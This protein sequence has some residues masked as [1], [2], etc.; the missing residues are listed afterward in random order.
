MQKATRKPAFRCSRH[1]REIATGDRGELDGV[2]EPLTTD[3]G[4]VAVELKPERDRQGM[5]RE[6]GV[7]LGEVRVRLET[8]GETRRSCSG[9]STAATATPMIAAATATATSTRPS[10][11]R[12]RARRTPRTT[13]IRIA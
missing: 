10:R 9:D 5:F 12:R 6:D 13:A 7:V 1:L 2:A 4:A 3:P 8:R 11:K